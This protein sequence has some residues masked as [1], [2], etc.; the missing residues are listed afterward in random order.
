M[1]GT[2][3]HIYPV[4]EKG[5]IQGDD[6]YQV[7]FRK[8]TLHGV[9]F[10]GLFSGLRVSYQIQNGWLGREAVNVHLVPSDQNCRNG[11]L[12]SNSRRRRACPRDS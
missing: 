2:I 4:Q 9:E 1:E 7:P 6:G 8:S 3:W 10:R 5:M 11:D 12:L